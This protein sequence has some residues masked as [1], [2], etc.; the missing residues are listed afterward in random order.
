MQNT[1]RLAGHA[2]EIKSIYKD[3]HTLCAHYQVDDEAEYHISTTSADID[4]E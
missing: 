3:V 1:Y 4:F 2:I